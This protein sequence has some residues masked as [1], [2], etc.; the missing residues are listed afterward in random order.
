MPM[1]TGNELFKVKLILSPVKVYQIGFL[2]EDLMF[3]LY[4]VQSKVYNSGS[5]IRNSNW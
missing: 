4:R 2:Y 1:N 3:E 5:K